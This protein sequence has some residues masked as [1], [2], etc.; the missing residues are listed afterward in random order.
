ML[1]GLKQNVLLQPP[2][3]RQAWQWESNVFLAWHGKEMPSLPT[4]EGKVYCFDRGVVEWWQSG[5]NIRSWRKTDS[6]R[7]SAK[8]IFCFLYNYAK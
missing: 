6:Y 3:L 5:R 8:E 1:Q 7:V 2:F 4:V